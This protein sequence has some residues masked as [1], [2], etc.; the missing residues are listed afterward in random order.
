MTD[1]KLYIPILSRLLNIYLNRKQNPE[2]CYTLIQ[3]KILINKIIVLLEDLRKQ[4]YF[5][6]L[7]LN[8]IKADGLMDINSS[9]EKLR[10]G[11]DGAP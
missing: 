1:K 8:Q 5:I 6:P 2:K 4:R 10:K 9:P 11:V 7:Y 3:L